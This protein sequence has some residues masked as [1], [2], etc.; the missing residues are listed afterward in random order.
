MT[1]QQRLHSIGVITLGL[2]IAACGSAGRNSSGARQPEEPPSED[3]SALSSSDTSD[4]AENDPAR[5]DDPD[6]PVP[7]VG[8]RTEQKRTMDA[9]VQMTLSREDGSA[10]GLADRRWT[11]TEGR[12]TNVEKVGKGVVTRFS[13]LYGQREGQGLEAWTPLPTQSKGYTVKA[14][15]SALEIVDQT[16]SSVSDQ[17]RA[18][19]EREYGY[20]GKPHPLLV[21]LRQG[22][23]GDEQTLSKEAMLALVGFMPE[24]K[25]ERMQARVS[26]TEEQNGRPGTRLDVV[27]KGVITSQEIQLAMDLAGPALVDSQTG[28]VIA[29]SLEGQIKVSGHYSH[30]GHRLTATGEGKIKLGRETK[31]F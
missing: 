25:L 12:R 2:L 7:E 14:S 6:Y 21:L 24:M 13:V 8:R 16:G 3:E 29:L 31:I 27:L 23:G 17:E 11:F 10:G 19:V 9:R 28:W 5:T 30:K 4:T 22:R 1:R 26:G 18:V 15:G 20:I